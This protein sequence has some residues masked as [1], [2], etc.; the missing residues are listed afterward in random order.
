MEFELTGT[1][2]EIKQVQ[3]GV[4]KGT[5]NE[6]QKIEFVID[7]NAE[8]DNIF[9]FEIFKADKVEQ[10]TKYNKVGDVVKV[11]FNIKCN[12]WNGKHFTSLSAWK[13]DNR[14]EGITNE[15][16]PQPQPAGIE[17]DTDE[18]PF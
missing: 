5:G 6:W 15:P 7:T 11:A 8:Y 18:M 10:F 14:L 12:A 13:V 2:T 9:C 4:A 16:T 17:D 3:K 1:I